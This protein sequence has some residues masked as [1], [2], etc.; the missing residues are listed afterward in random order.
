MLGNDQL[1]SLPHS[2]SFYESS[3]RYQEVRARS[4]EA[5]RWNISRIAIGLMNKSMAERTQ[6]YVR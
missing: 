2:L 4:R 6:V 1:R 5:V 3:G